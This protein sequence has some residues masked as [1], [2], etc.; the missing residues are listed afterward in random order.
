[1]TVNHLFVISAAALESYFYCI[2]WFGHG[3]KRAPISLQEKEGGADKRYE[4]ARC[5]ISKL[6]VF[7]VEFRNVFIIY[8]S[9]RP[10]SLLKGAG[11]SF[12]VAFLLW[13]LCGLLSYTGALC[14]AEL[15]VRVKSSGGHYVYVKESYGDRVGFMFLWAQCI[16]IL[17]MGLSIAALA[18]AEYILRPA[19]LDCPAWIPREGKR[20]IATAALCK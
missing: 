7:P 3:G 12:G 5:K 13:I 20:S 15:G 17:P 19:F 9:F 14:F 18:T 8:S 11:G 10:Q 1:M 6:H 2:E 16:L 4:Q